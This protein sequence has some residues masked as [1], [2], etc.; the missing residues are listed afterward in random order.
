MINIADF[1]SIEALKNAIKEKMS[2]TLQTDVAN[3]VIRVM[4]GSIQE[5]VYDAYTPLVYVRRGYQ[6]GLGDP[7]NFTFDLI[8]NNEINVYNITP[9]N[10]L[11]NP[12]LIE[13]HTLTEAI[14][15]GNF[16]D[17]RS[18]GARPFVAE[19]KKSLEKNNQHK[20]A[21]VDGLRKRGITV[22]R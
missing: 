4:Q 21:M 11:Y 2:E 9:P 16:Y 19:A 5:F 17:Y 18:P 1:T 10:E 20:I 6:G 22:N 7:D 12:K 15:T 8:S 3:E 13:G 14:V